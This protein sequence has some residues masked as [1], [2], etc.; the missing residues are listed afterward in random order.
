[1]Y[2]GLHIFF[3]T[4]RY[5]DVFPARNRYPGEEHMHVEVWCERSLLCY[6][7]MQ[8]RSHKVRSMYERPC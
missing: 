2:L 6:L 3:V 1:M 5:L 7:A 4:V 8:A